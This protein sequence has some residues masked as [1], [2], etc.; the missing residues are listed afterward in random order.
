MATKTATDLALH[1]NRFPHPRCT[2]F[3]RS[4]VRVHGE[5]SLLAESLVSLPLPRIPS[6]FVLMSRHRIAL[7]VSQLTFIIISS[8]YTMDYSYVLDNPPPSPSST[9]LPHHPTLTVLTPSPLAP[10]RTALPHHPP[11]IPHLLR[12]PFPSSSSPSPRAPS[13]PSPE[14]LPSPTVLTHS[15]LARPR[16]ALPHHPLTCF[17][18]LRRLRSP[19]ET[20]FSLRLPPAPPPLLSST[21]FLSTSLTHS[22]VANLISPSSASPAALFGARGKHSRQRGRDG[23]AVR[24]GV[25][26]AHWAPS[27]R[28]AFG[29]A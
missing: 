4:S 29:L 9:A 20:S 12:A 5:R 13:P 27:C 8:Y 11:P 7:Y 16:A 23:R 15:R 18:R 2:R 24:V 14:Q 26:L 25:A 10:P 17:R 22:Q 6:P 28:R 1:L 3:G 19:F 21:R